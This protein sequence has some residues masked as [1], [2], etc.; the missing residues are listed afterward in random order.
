MMRKGV[1]EKEIY[2][3]Y[4]SGNFYDMVFSFACMHMYCAT[5]HIRWKYMLG[6]MTN[7]PFDFLPHF[8]SFQK[9]SMICKTK[10]QG[11]R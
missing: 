3:K 8:F 4:T 9:T 11:H 1:V 7:I 6:I 2:L 5:F 10:Y